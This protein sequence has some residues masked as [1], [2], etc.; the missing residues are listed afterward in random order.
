MA[1]NRSKHDTTFTLYA[2][3]MSGAPVHLLL[4]LDIE[5]KAHDKDE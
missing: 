4:P 2:D 1:I 3:Y 5:E